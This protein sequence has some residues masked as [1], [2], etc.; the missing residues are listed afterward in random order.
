MC[1]QRPFLSVFTS[2]YNREA[3]LERTY[4]SL[5]RQKC[6][7]FEWIIVDDG[8][9]D[10]TR[11][12]AERWRRSDNGFTIRYVWK[13]NGGLH[14]GYNTAISLLRG[15]LAVCID[16]DDCM[17]DDAVEKIRA[18]WRERGG[19]A[20]GGIIGLDVPLE[21]GLIRE[22]L[23]EQPSLDLIAW[24][25]GRGVRRHGD[26]KL[27]VRSELY[28][29]VAPMRVFPGEKYFNPHYMHLQIA[30]RYEFLVLNE[31]LCL[32]DYQSDGMSAR[33]FE[34][35]RNSPNSFLEIRKQYYSFPRLSLAFKLRN[36]V[37]FVSSAL[38]A[39]RFREEFRVSRYKGVLLLCFLPGLLLTGLVILKG[40]GGCP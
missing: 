38:L 28:R 16:S 1:E 8:S 14:T 2:T 31:C 3:L 29:Q 10:G 39:R 21:S 35:Y 32:V 17:P 22:R 20:F 37:H 36:G 30:E 26:K 15:E 7:D 13:E 4:E 11:E 40:Q 18:C 34:Q 33:I 23:P 12:R 5:R 9:T 25:F 19:A 24:S 6:K 27:V